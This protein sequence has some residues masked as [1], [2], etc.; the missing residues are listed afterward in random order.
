MKKVTAAAAALSLTLVIPAVANARPAPGSPSTRAT[1]LSAPQAKALSTGV[2]HRVI[3]V[4]KNQL[5]QLPASRAH[6]SARRHAVAQIQKS[7]RADLTST[8]ARNVTS[9][10]TINAVA[11][12]VSAG[13]QRRLAAVPGR[14]RGR[15]GP[16]HP[17]RLTGQGRGSTD[18]ADR[19]PGSRVLPGSRRRPAAHARGARHHARRLHGPVRGDGALARHH[20]R[21][22]QGRL[23]RRR[24]RH[25]QHRLHP[26]RRQPRVRRLQ[27]LQRR[28]H[29]R[30]DRR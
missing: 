1:T 22:R 20:R 15:P 13:E 9:Y 14:R 4:F 16:D 12:T 29:G 27:G 2:T 6:V 7:V 21:G 19:E 18:R 25:Q 28:G 26:R 11:A 5:G 10:T 30:A 17:P 8:K 24:P 3:V 23:H